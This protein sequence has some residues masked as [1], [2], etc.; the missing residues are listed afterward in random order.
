MNNNNIN[1][2]AAH[3]RDTF[4]EAEK[5]YLEYL[6]KNDSVMNLIRNLNGNYSSDLLFKTAKDL[7][8]RVEAGEFDD[9]EMKNVEAQITVLLAA[10]KDKVLMR[11]LVRTMEKYEA[12]T[13]NV[14]ELDE[15]HKENTY[16]VEY[17]R[18]GRR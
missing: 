11:I 13:Q 9:E 12:E 4:L 3:L 18:G 17:S 14:Q 10:I 7:I 15:I 5:E 1:G 2:E 8:D 16:R 6:L